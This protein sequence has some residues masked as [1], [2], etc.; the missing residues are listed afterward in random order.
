[1]FLIHSLYIVAQ[2]GKHK[3]KFNFIALMDS[4]IE[5]IAKSKNDKHLYKFLYKIRTQYIKNESDVVSIFKIYF[6]L[7]SLQ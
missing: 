5:Q 3:E 4:L 6:F 2:F 1:M 7:P